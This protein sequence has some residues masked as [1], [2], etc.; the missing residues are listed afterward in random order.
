MPDFPQYL[1]LPLPIIPMKALMTWQCQ[2][3]KLSRTWEQ[4]EWLWNSK[5]NY[6]ATHSSHSMK[7]Y[8]WTRTNV[9]VMATAFAG[10]KNLPSSEASGFARW[11]RWGPEP[12]MAGYH[13]LWGVEWVCCHW[14]FIWATSCMEVCLLKHGT[15]GGE[16]AVF[17]KCCVHIEVAI[18]LC[19]L[20]L[21]WRGNV[22]DSFCGW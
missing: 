5:V 3:S 21:S 2:F 11:F 19:N 4:Y 9:E 1:K 18:T 7:S 10:W 16:W 17:W 12:K 15:C 22:C 6:P 8:M 20:E 13:K 14:S